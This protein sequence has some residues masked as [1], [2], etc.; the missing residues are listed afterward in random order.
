[1]ASEAG[2]STAGNMIKNDA[3]ATEDQCDQFD[4]IGKDYKK[5]LRFSLVR[6]P[7][8][9]FPTDCNKLSMEP[10]DDGRPTILEKHDK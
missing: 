2:S 3:I 5:N 1:M 6:D 7:F 8:L 9:D 10:N 4:L